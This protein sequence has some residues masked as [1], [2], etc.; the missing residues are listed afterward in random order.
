MRWRWP[1]G[2]ASRTEENVRALLSLS[3]SACLSHS[4]SFSFSLSLTHT[5]THYLNSTE[6]LHV[7]LFWRA[8]SGSDFFVDNFN[9]RL[10]HEG[11]FLSNPH[12]EKL[13]QFQFCSRLHHD[14]RWI[15]AASLIWWFWVFCTSVWRWRQNSKQRARVTAE[16]LL[17]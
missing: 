3:L 5:H 4:F 2:R 6:G 17:L 16:D 7:V 8:W 12:K 15:V 11:D 13:F 10:H 9:D 14:C 1:Q